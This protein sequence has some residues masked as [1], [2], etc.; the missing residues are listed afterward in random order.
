MMNDD[1]NTPYKVL[2]PTRVWLSETARQLASIHNMSEADMAKH[3][4]NQHRLKQAGLI[5]TDGES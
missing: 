5:Q 2:S 1:G 4:L 3:L